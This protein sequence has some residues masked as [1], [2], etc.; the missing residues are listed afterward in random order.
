M[1]FNQTASHTNSTVSEIETEIAPR[2]AAHNDAL[3]LNAR[4]FDRVKTLYE[5]REKLDLDAEDLHLLERYYTDFVRAGA[6]LSPTDQEQLRDLNEEL[7]TLATRFKENLLADSNAAAVEVD[8]VA[9]LDGL[10]E[11]TIAAA[12]EAAR[13]RGLDGSYVLTLIL[14]TAQPALNSLTNRDLRRRIYEASTTRGA[15]GNA[16]DNHGLVARI[17]HLRAVR[18]ELLGYPN[19][20]TYVIADQT[21][22]TT[23]AVET[24][25]DRLARAAV[26]NATVEESTLREVATTDH[27]ADP[28]LRAWDWQ[29]YSEKVRQVQYELDS[30]KLREYFDL[31]R[32][33]HDGVFFAAERL[34]GLSFVERHDLPTYHR[35]VRVFEVFEEDGSALGLFLGDYY[36]RDSK[37]GGAWMSSFVRQSE[38]LGQ[39]PVV[40]NNLNIAKPSEGEPTLLTFDE[41]T[42]VFH[43]FGH[44]LHGLF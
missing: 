27:G 26:A 29:Y 9:E 11:D 16:H 24:I 6:E 20:A 40:L 32:V 41:V 36:T 8:N 14:P 10:A 43:E 18:A 2:L 39:R 21:A 4:L 3:Y 44:A 5:A 31:D 13:D 35:D 38:L 19:H 30:A 25:L 23:A 37:R 28:E 15:R 7:T 12:A 1:F 42:T 17:A 22:Q 33:L 34:Y